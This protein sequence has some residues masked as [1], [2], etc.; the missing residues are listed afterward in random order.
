MT[1]FKFKSSSSLL[2]YAERFCHESAQR[3]Y[4]DV[5]VCCL[6]CTVEFSMHEHRNGHTHLD[7]PWL[8]KQF[9]AL[10][11]NNTK[12]LEVAFFPAALACCATLE[13]FA[14]LAAG[15]LNTPNTGRRSTPS[16]FI[17][18]LSKCTNYPASRANLLL[19]IFRHK[20]A[21]LSAP[22]PFVRVADSIQLED[23][24]CIPPGSLVTWYLGLGDLF[25]HLQITLDREREN[26]ESLG[27]IEIC[28][29]GFSLNVH[30]LLLDTV[31]AIGGPHGYLADI[32]S[33]S[34]LGIRQNFE[35][36]VSDL[37]PLGN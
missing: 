10:G 34:T 13:L 20:I 2:A 15:N 12:A 36:G 8:A 5:T 31:Q 26:S 23:G 35:K 17:A 16:P 11:F 19:K 24:R 6:P 27:E 9:T 33:D 32:M 14:G 22:A 30:L 3:L 29:F 18:F 25:P 4:N 1:R 37:Y 28:S 21:H 7:F